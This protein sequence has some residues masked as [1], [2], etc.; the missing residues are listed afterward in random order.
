MTPAQRFH[1]RNSATRTRVLV[2]VAAI[3]ALLALISTLVLVSRASAPDVTN[4]AQ[5]QVRSPDE[6]ALAN[7]NWNPNQA[8]AGRQEL[9]PANTWSENFGK[10]LADVTGVDADV[11]LYPPGKAPAPGSIITGSGEEEIIIEDEHDA[12]AVSALPP[13][14]AAPATQSE[15]PAKNNT[16]YNA[17]SPVEHLLNR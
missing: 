11:H 7:E 8:L 6:E 16:P 4:R 17:R 9:P 3:I 2:I 15:A 5:T 10:V 1:S 14:K 12:N 13:S